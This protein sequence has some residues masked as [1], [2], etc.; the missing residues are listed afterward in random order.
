MEYTVQSIMKRRKILRNFSIV[1]LSAVVFL[2]FFSRTIDTFL[3]PEV[4]FCQVR[5]GALTDMLEFAG[6]IEAKDIEKIY[7]EGDW[8]ISEVLVKPGEDVVVGLDLARVDTADMQMKLKKKELEVLAYENALEK[9]KTEDHRIDLSPYRREAE[10][11]LK[12]VEKCESELERTRYLYEAGSEPLIAVKNLEDK[13]ESLKAQYAEKLET[14][15][16]K[17]KEIIAAAAEHERMLKE[18]TLELDIKRTELEELR[19]SM[20]SEDG[21]LRCNVEGRIRNVAVES[22]SHTVKGQEMFDII[23]TGTPLS[24][25]WKADP[26]KSE[27]INVKDKIAMV[28]ERGDKSTVIFGTIN[29]KTYLAKEKK[30]EFVSRLD[31]DKVKLGEGEENEVLLQDGDTVTVRVTKRSGEFEFIV[32]ARCVNSLDIDTDAVYVLRERKGAL[33]EE[34][35]VEE[36]RVNVLKSNGYDSAVEGSLYKDDRIVEYSTKPLSSEVRVKLK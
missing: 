7:S 2:T 17:E 10:R 28:Y 12:E 9:Y 6:E 24:V 13:L 34:F 31:K 14:L 16:K 33:G 26:E 18:K 4:S 21:Y 22:G 20:P 11:T 29:T 23:K 1:F 30:Y 32:P 8:E 25:R 35:Y 36:V 5:S 27:S 19:K 3:L 15:E